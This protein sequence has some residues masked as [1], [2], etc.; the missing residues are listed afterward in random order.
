MTALASTP[1]WRTLCLDY[2]AEV[3]GCV[4]TPHGDE[5]YELIVVERGT[6]QIEVEG[7]L[8]CLA[9]GDAT[10]I[11]PTR[12]YRG[13]SGIA[14]AI[15]IARFDASEVD[16]T[17][18]SACARVHRLAAERYEAVCAVLRLLS[19]TAGDQSAYRRLV[20]RLHFTAVVASV[21]ESTDVREFVPGRP[22]ALVHDALE[23]VDRRY[24]ENIGPAEIARELGRH[25]AYLTNLVREATGKSLGTWLI[26]RRLAAARVLL[27][28]TDDS[29]GDIAAAVG[30]VDASHFARYFTRR[31]G[32]P[33]A[34]WRRR[35]SR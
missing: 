30:Y 16:I 1:E 20:R 4:R 14:P 9:A 26:E 21:F 35:R 29:V 22:N 5:Q 3:G 23:I 11:A 19:Q 18:P 6:V 7:H 33:P 24:G 31:Y 2:V 10:L 15:W 17:L 34:R 12:F 28:N 8:A 25:P 27:C 13:V 32:T